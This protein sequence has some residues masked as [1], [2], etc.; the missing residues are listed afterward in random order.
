[1]AFAAGDSVT[2]VPGRK[3]QDFETGNSGT[4][5]RVDKES[6]S[7]QAGRLS[8]LSDFERLSRAPE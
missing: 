3:F 2:V 1:M 7:C 6:Q 5:L 8:R 4:V